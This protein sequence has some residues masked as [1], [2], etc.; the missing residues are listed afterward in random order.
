MPSSY[1]GAEASVDTQKQSALDALAQFGRRGLEAA[2]V[3]QREGNKIQSDAASEN[4]TFANDLGVG[5]AGQKELAALTNPGK[6][7]YAANGAGSVNLMRTENDALGKVQS[8]YYDQ[9]KQ[10]LPLERASADQIV[11]QYKAA[12]AQRQAD[13]AA[14]AELQRQAIAQAALQAQMQREDMERQ[15]ALWRLLNPALSPTTGSLTP[16]R[17]TRTIL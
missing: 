14:Q 13:T 7:A 3:A 2:V 10:V 16:F 8:N 12:Y 5:T 11:E 6:A 1:D 15:A 17:P 4:A 9:V